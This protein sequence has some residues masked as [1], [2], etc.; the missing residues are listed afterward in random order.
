MKRYSLIILFTL[1][2]LTGCKSKTSFSIP[3]DKFTINI[4]DNNKQYISMPTPPDTLGMKVLTE[5]KEMIG[6]GS[7]GFINSL[8]IVKTAIQS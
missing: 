2:I 7:T 5:M 6:T 8:I 3:F 1:L 4:Y